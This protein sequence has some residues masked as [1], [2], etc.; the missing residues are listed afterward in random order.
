[1]FQIFVLL[2]VIGTRKVLLVKLTIFSEE[3]VITLF[4]IFIV[5]VKV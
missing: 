1:M 5:S 4:F 3:I 2:I